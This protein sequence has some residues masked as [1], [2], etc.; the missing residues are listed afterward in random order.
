MVLVEVSMLKKILFLLLFPIAALAATGDD[1]P[2][3]IAYQIPVGTFV[4]GKSRVFCKMLID[5]ESSAAGLSSVLDLTAIPP[6]RALP[7]YALATEL[8]IK[9][10]VDGCSAGTVTPI[11]SETNG[12]LANFFSQTANTIGLAD[13]GNARI[14]EKNAYGP[15]ISATWTGVSCTT[16]F[17]I[18]VMGYK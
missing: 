10:V 13:G 1:C 4:E 9:L 11:H 16:N 3:T 17:S 14:S 18:A 5:G 2:E 8:I 6:T 15:F 7:Q 12:G